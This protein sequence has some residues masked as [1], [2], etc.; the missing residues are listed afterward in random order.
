V[1]RCTSWR[2]QLGPLFGIDGASGVFFERLAYIGTHLG[3]TNLP[4][5]LLGVGAIAVLALGEWQFPRIPTALLVVLASILLLT[6]TDLQQQGVAIVGSIPSGLPSLTIP[7]VPSSSTLR[8]LIPIAGALF[9]LSYVEGISAIETLARENDYDIDAN[10]EHLSTGVAN[11]AAG[12]G[13]G[14]AVG[15]SMS[16]SALN[17]AVG[18]KI[19]VTSAIVAGALVVVLLFLTEIFTNLPEAVLAAVVIVAQNA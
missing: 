11:L 10:Q 7:A 4:T 8:S 3:A 19:Q 5:L 12:F 18:G 14:F 6:V 17:D 16:R 9:L 2:P 13:G 15:G 1:Q